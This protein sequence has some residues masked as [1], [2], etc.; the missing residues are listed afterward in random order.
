MW[1]QLKVHEGMEYSTHLHPHP[2]RRWRVR[3][4]VQYKITD[5]LRYVWVSLV[6]YPE[7]T[8]SYIDADGF[9]PLENLTLGIQELRRFCL[10]S[11]IAEYI[12]PD[13]HKSMRHTRRIS[14]RTSYVSFPSA[15]RLLSSHR[16]VRLPLE[17]WATRAKTSSASSQLEV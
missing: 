7:S 6:F 16:P 4:K 13:I 12:V 1:S 8:V 5:V 3:H 17:L 11:R 15:S 9:T 10:N 2:T 14:L